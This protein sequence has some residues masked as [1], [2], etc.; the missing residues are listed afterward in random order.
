MKGIEEPPPHGGTAI[1]FL[2]RRPSAHLRQ[3]AR[4]VRAMRPALAVVTVSDQSEGL[5]EEP[6]AREIFVPDEECLDAGY[7][8]VN[9]LARKQI[10]PWDRALFHAVAA[11]YRNCWFIEDDVLFSDAAA[12]IRLVEHFADDDSDVVCAEFADKIGD[13]DWPHWYTSPEFFPDVVAARAFVPLCRLSRQMLEAIDG[14]AATN[15]KL[16]FIETMVGSVAKAFHMRIEAIDPRMAA[17]RYRPAFTRVE[18]QALFAQGLL[19]VHPCR[20]IVE[21]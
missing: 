18:A 16:C 19:A 15:G 17:V 10:T 11:Q 14:I 21:A 2:C 12:L 13:P 7:R 5:L 9:H 1:L 8:W 3:L 4:Q 20:E 6:A